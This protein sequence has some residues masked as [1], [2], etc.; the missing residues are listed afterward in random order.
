MQRLEKDKQLRIIYRNA[1]LDDLTQ[2]MNINRV[3]LPENYTYSFFHSLLM[4]YPKAFWVAEHEGK[5]V[6][7]VMCRIERILSKID[8]LRIR[9]AGHIVSVAMLPEYR[10]RGIGFELMRRTVD[11][12]REVYNC[13]EAYLEVRVSNEPAINLYKKLGFAIVSVQKSYYVDGEDAYVMARR[14][15]HQ[16]AA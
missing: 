16:G 10:R 3:C 14:L 13:D 4:E 7:Y 6:G 2:V 1:T 12:L 5:V 15:K 8:P 9:K 11:S